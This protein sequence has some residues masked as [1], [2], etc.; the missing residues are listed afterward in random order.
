MAEG[1][2]LSLFELVYEH[3]LETLRRELLSRPSELHLLDRNGDSLLHLAIRRSD[4]AVVRELLAVGFDVNMRSAGNWT[5]MEEAMACAQASGEP[6]SLAVLREI[7]HAVQSDE[8]ARWA[9]RRETVLGAMRAM[10]DFSTVL[11]WRFGSY[12]LGLSTLLRRFLPN[13]T[14]RI[15]KRGVRVR[16]DSTLAGLDYATLSWQRGVLSLIIRFDAPVGEPEIMMVD[17]RRRCAPCANDACA[18]RRPQP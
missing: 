14:Y 11:A 5:P 10:P 6:D 13:D 12:M 17:H 9:E 2:A 1:Q 7:H 3:K 16:V 15:R 18:P 8:Q 4:A